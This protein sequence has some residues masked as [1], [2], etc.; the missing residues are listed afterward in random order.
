MDVEILVHGV[1]EGQEFYGIKEESAHIDLFYDNSKESVKFVIETK[2]LG[3]TAYAY[4]TYLRYKDVIGYGGRPGS[5]FGL[6]LRLDK[7]YLDVVHMY[8]MLDM[9]FKR[10]VVGTILAPLEDGGGYKYMVPHI[11]SQKM[12]IERLEKGLIQ[13]IQG[14]CV[15][16]NFLNI[17]DSF[18]HPITSAASC[19]IADITDNAMLATIKKYSKVV[20]SPD[21]KLNVVKEYE[22]KLQ[23]A[24]GKG[25]NLVA[26]KDKKIA[27]KDGEISSL[28]STVSTQKARID[29]LQT[30]NMQLKKNGN[31][32]QM[33]SGIKEPINSLADYFHVQDSQKKP[34]KPSYG[35]KNFILGIAGC[36]LSAI[37]V[38]LCIVSLKKA[39]NKPDTNGNVSILTQQVESLTNENNQLK[40]E[41]SE[42]DKTISDLHAQLAS[43]IGGHSETPE[44]T[45]LKIDVEGYSKGAP[46]YC[47]KIY[48]IKVLNDKNKAY[49][50][51]GSWTIT[52][53]TIKQ[54]KASDSQIKIQPTSAGKVTISYASDNCTCNS[55][56][57]TSELQQKQD[58][59]FEIV[60]SPQVSEVEV[61]QEY[62]FSVS[63]YEGKGTWRLDG[64][65]TNDD[66]SGRQIKVIVN[67]N[68]SG[69]KATVSYTPEAGTKKSKSF[70]YKTNE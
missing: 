32:T 3:D 16:S 2:K 28:K 10:Y 45:T 40:L 33:I 56:E 29:V 53:A 26:E 20:L 61:G 54:G 22:K 19:N 48:T 15:L 30:E 62:T 70:K 41:V 12:E 49:S 51:N 46:L 24:E 42:K 44:K 9:I 31:L 8:N 34:Q 43:N 35:F 55:R 57:F 65:D 68:G 52:N 17:D 36:V 38:A 37:I 25:G 50:G 4:Y 64:F 21:Y 60:V 13:L 14:T 39:P 23:D 59:S 69:G 67:A 18:I 58:I 7:Y 47:D 11:S 6:T 66:K 63:G 1:S 5:Y 27:E